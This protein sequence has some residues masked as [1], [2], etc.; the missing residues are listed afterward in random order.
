MALASR[1]SAKKRNVLVTLAVV[2]VLVLTTGCGEEDELHQSTSGGSGSGTSDSDS[3][4]DN[5]SDGKDDADNTKDGN[6]NAAK[7]GAACFPGNWIV[8]IQDIQNYMESVAGPVTIKS[9]GNI[10]LTYNEDGTAQTNY[11]HWN[12]EVT[13]DGSTSTVERHGIDQ[14]TYTASED[15]TFTASDT[16][17]G[18]VTTMTLRSGGQV[19]TSMAIDPEPSVFETGKYTCSG[20]VLTMIVDGYNLTSYREH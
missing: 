9:S 11:D 5:G 19:I 8:N 2:S 6:Q 10:L 20:D 13:V 4:G 14:G 16:S 18:S 1:T 12:N 17:I 15:G 7:T 3:K